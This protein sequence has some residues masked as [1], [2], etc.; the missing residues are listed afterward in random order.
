MH[1]LPDRVVEMI[2]A[3][4]LN[5]GAPMAELLVE[6]RISREVNVIEV[7]VSDTGAATTRYLPGARM[8]IRILSLWN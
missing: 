4:E 7:G 8:M 3:I 6:V 2:T 1:F 5:K